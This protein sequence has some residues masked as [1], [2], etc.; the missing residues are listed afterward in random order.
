MRMFLLFGLV[1]CGSIGLADEP[2]PKSLAE[3]TGP[4]VH[5]EMRIVEVREGLWESDSKSL[6]DSGVDWD[7]W[8]NI[9]G[10]KVISAP[11]VIVT[12][13]RQATVETTTRGPIEYLEKTGDDR[14]SIKSFEPDSPLGT[15]IGVLATTDDG[16]LKVSV[17]LTMLV[18]TTDGTR[19]I[20]GVDVPIGRP[21]IGKQALE[22]AFRWD[23]GEVYL[24]ELPTP[25]D[26]QAFLLVRARTKK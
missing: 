4:V 14:L 24:V 8:K 20:S 2:A 1:L 11:N 15:R 25:S 17:E 23:D 5:I 7:I 10:A 12:S 21:V 13:G 26:K 6:V 9:P 22:T 18:G 3:P 16:E 19:L